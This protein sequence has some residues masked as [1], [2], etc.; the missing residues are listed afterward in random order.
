MLKRNKVGEERYCVASKKEALFFRDRELKNMTLR[1]HIKYSAIP[2]GILVPFLGYKVIWFLLGSILID[3]DHYI[4]Y[5]LRF[6]DFNVARMFKYYHEDLFKEIN[7]Y[8]LNIFHTVEFL[9]VLLI[10][11]FYSSVFLLM[12]M[13]LVFHLLLDSIHLYK[14][15][16]L[17]ARAHSIVEY[18]VRT[19]R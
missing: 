2:C 18:L 11:S 10:L 9:I 6:K 8:V 7:P 15:G 4:T 1:E 5:V 14:I 17:S 16:R 12:L 13:G 3:A 19:S